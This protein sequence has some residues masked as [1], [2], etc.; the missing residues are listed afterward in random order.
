[1]TVTDNVIQIK[2]PRR[3][4]GTFHAVGCPD[5]SSLERDGQP[6]Y[7]YN[8]LWTA[9][10]R[11]LAEV[12]FADGLWLLADPTVDLVPG[13]YLDYDPERV[14]IARSYG[15]TWNGWATPVIEREVLTELLVD[16]EEPHRWDGNAVWID[17]DETPFRPC[18]DGLYDTG[19][20]GWTFSP[21]E[22]GSVRNRP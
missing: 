7:E 5:A 19:T 9:D 11:P 10:D 6:Y 20:L 16:L 15:P 1:M 3:P 14:Y 22:T 18:I 21:L 12:L 4:I 8:R 13:F 17:E 2:R